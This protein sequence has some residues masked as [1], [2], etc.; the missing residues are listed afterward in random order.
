MHSINNFIYVF[1]GL[2][3][4]LLGSRSLL[5]AIDGQYVGRLRMATR[6]DRGLGQATR[7]HRLRMLAFAGTGLA[8]GGLSFGLVISGLLR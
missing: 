4:I 8:L 5:D 6:K 2:A 1:P 7:I 3:F